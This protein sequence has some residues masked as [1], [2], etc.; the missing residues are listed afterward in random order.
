[1]SNTRP[2]SAAPHPVAASTKAENVASTFPPH[3]AAGYHDVQHDAENPNRILIVGANS[4]IG[5]ALR[6][7]LADQGIGAFGTTRRAT[8]VN[9][10]TLYLDLENPDFSVFDGAFQYVVICAA[11]TSI[12][13]CEAMPEKY[14]AINVTHTLDLIKQLAASGSFIVYLSSNAVFNGEKPFYKT[15]DPTCPGNLYGLFKCEIEA[16]LAAEIPD[17]SCVLRL[18]KVISADTPFIERWKDDARNG[19]QIRTFSDKLISPVGIEEVVETIQ[20]LIMLKARGIHHLGGNT[21]MSFTDYARWLFQNDPT[22]TALIKAESDPTSTKV[23]HNSLMTQLP[24]HPRNI[25]EGF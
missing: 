13:Q 3:V 24:P 18:T 4:Q 11:T 21:E 7:H 1:M 22:A 14:R 25:Q 2:P 23:C 15:T 6:K 20:R 8:D 10:L 19:K 5:K 17:H 12:A 16:Y 9:A